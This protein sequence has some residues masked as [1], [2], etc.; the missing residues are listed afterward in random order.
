S[1]WWRPVEWATEV[2][3]PLREI[4]M[5]ASSA[6]AAEPLARF[7]GPDGRLLPE[8]DGMR[9][10]LWVR[11]AIAIARTVA[12]ASGM[13]FDLDPAVA[14]LVKEASQTEVLRSRLRAVAL[15]DENWSA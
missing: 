3:D 5:D 2:P 10:S 8:P 13:V 6:E 1:V 9:P 14:R 15:G 12:T 7:F 11:R 4:R